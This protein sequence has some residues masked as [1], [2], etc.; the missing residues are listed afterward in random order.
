VPAVAGQCPACE[1]MLPGSLRLAASERKRASGNHPGVEEAGHRA[2]A[3]VQ[4]RTVYRH[5]PSGIW[6]PPRQPMPSNSASAAC[7][8]GCGCTLAVKRQPPQNITPSRGGTGTHRATT[9]R[10]AAKTADGG[11]EACWFCA[12]HST[13]GP[14]FVTAHGAHG[15]APS[16]RSAVCTERVVRR[17]R[18]VADGPCCASDGGF[19]PPGM[20]L[21]P[22]AQ[23]TGPGGLWLDLAFAVRPCCSHRPRRPIGNGHSRAVRAPRPLKRIRPA[24]E[25]TVRRT[26][27]FAGCDRPEQV[28]R[29]PHPQA[30]PHR[31]CA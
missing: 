1:P 30:Q 18:R 5:S 26:P 10:R 6:A 17:C 28:P 13:R 25:G 14:G 7:S 3:G 19:G 31:L 21:R 29:S 11:G 22:G 9:D 24:A 4:E 12:A 15:R 2:A 27:R 20:P 23:S 8:R 16:R